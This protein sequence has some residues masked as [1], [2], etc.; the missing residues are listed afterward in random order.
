MKSFI[1]LL[2][3]AT[4]I[5]AY[6]DEEVKEEAKAPNIEGWTVSDADPPKHGFQAVRMSKTGTALKPDDARQ[7]VMESVFY[8]DPD[9][10]GEYG[11][12]YRSKNDRGEWVTFAKVWGIKKVEGKYM[13]DEDR[14]GNGVPDGNGEMNYAVLDENGKWVPGLPGK[15]IMAWKTVWND[16]DTKD[17]PVGFSYCLCYEDEGDASGLFMKTGNVWIE[18]PEAEKDEE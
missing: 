18:K 16:S 10:P 9:N 15:T 14:D 13:Q 12:I 4:A 5:F 11:G 3:S 17:Y 6:P 1:A 8:E 7:P 2:V